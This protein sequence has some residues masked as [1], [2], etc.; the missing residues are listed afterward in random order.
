M[1]EVQPASSQ[2]AAGGA[3][4]VET[5]DERAQATLMRMADHVI[6]GRV[7]PFLGAG[8][9]Y[10]SM[11]MNDGT[12]FVEHTVL[13]IFQNLRGAFTEHGGDAD[14]WLRQK[15]EEHAGR[16]RLGEACEV[17]LA[18]LP[19]NTRQRADK[20][21]SVL[22][23]A[24]FRD[25][26]PAVAHRMIA[27]L[28][29]EGLISEVF[30]TNYDCAV[31]HAFAQA[32]GK[33]F[34]TSDP[35]T[36][37]DKCDGLHVTYDHRSYRK[38]GRGAGIRRRPNGEPALRVHKLN[39]CARQLGLA[40]RLDR[41]AEDCRH[42]DKI[43]LTERQLQG[44]GSRGWA[45]DLVR[46][47]LR[48]SVLIFSGFG[49]EEPQ[50]RHTVGLVMEEFR[51]DSD[52][53]ST[54]SARPRDLPNAIFVSGYGQADPSFPQWQ[55]MQ[56]VAQAAGATE[57][58]SA[59][60]QLFVGLAESHSFQ[61]SC[62]RQP[63]RLSADEFW[64]EIGARAFHRRLLEVF[65]RADCAAARAFAPV[66]RCAD[67]LAA[68]AAHRLGTTEE[69]GDLAHALLRWLGGVHQTVSFSRWIHAA[70]WPGTACGTG[71]FHPISAH[72]ELLARIVIV[73]NS[74]GVSPVLEGDE[75]CA[76]LPCRPV[77][78]ADW[79]E[80][81]RQRSRDHT[82][83]R[84]RLNGLGHI[85]PELVLSPRGT[86][87][88]SAIRTTDR[89]RSLAVSVPELL[90]ANEQRAGTPAGVDRLL[91]HT[92]LFPTDALRMQQPSVRRS[93]NR[94]D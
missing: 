6:E 91:R 83:Q 81:G 61:F 17:L 16:R 18:V 30:T 55:A 43:L 4:R 90:S 71:R 21:C 69:P 24:A 25:L 53:P 89:G 33:S 80:Q 23:I 94:V 14:P 67:A 13:R 12:P 56:A 34:L 41:E 42:A 66:S 39:G 51:V 1:N 92:V 54:A 85:V 38:R 3:S 45:Q 49:N 76:E 63:D 79:P 65:Q 50:I 11:A 22:D 73:A 44:F 9:S 7:I 20:L 19:G 36:V 72:A 68:R 87:A 48:S 70:L 58:S 62:C 75:L 78:R 86:K 52:P 57:S 74:L 77:L 35:P 32:L 2:A 46:D 40:G 59:W 28:A 37:A 29:C 5:N 26:S 8:V 88:T 15:F 93:F 27:F 31:E 10:G 82:G 60:R 64:S 84:H 47:R